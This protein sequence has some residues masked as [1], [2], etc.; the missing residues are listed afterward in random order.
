MFDRRPTPE[1]LRKLFRYD[2][3]T[4][5]LF[6]R[7]RTP[8]MF[9]DGIRT[10]AHNCSIWNSTRSGAE[11]FTS[12]DGSGYKRG[13]IFSRAHLAHRV[14]WAIETGSW[15]SDQIDHINGVRDDNCIDNLR[16]VSQSENLRNQKIG[17]S[18]TSGVIGVSW[19][20][21]CLKWRAQ[22]RVAGVAKHL[23][24]FLSKREA[25]AARKSAE[26]RYGFHQNHG[27]A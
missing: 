20:P 15:P 10:A 22:I 2:A 26:V 7:D 18:N 1:L 5:K 24:L 21:T 27:R 25:I 19:H 13:Q 17:V 23:G 3:D 16:S 14:I 9:S 8:D 4:G 6:W 12:R 11:A